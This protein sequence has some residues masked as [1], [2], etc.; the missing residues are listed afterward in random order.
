MKPFLVKILHR[1]PQ[2]GEIISDGEFYVFMNYFIYI[3]SSSI[4]ISK[5]AS[6][7]N[8]IHYNIDGF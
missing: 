8:T 1:G 7:N 4:K 3:D 6:A 2:W 5:K